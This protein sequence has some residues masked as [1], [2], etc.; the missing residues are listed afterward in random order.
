MKKILGV[1]MAVGVGAAACSSPSHTAAPIKV[2]AIYPLTGLQAKGGGIDE[3]RGV[4][5]AADLVNRAGGVGGRPIR[6]VPL[7]VPGGKM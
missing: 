5:L 6:L 2:G 3:F 4:H 1:L 7:D